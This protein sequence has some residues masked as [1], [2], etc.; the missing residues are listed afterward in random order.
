[1]S[2]F[3]SDQLKKREAEAAKPVEETL[4]K[5]VSCR[6]CLTYHRFDGGFCSSDCERRW[7]AE[8]FALRMMTNPP[9]TIDLAEVNKLFEKARKRPRLEFPQRYPT[10]EFPAAR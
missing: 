6:Y 9:K 7:E 10:A 8:A 4:E 3:L 1:M 5:E 2:T